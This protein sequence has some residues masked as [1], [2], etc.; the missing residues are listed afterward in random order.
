MTEDVVADVSQLVNYAC[1][2]LVLVVRHL[3]V[4]LPRRSVPSEGRSG[5][6]WRVA[7]A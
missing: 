1:A 3:D 6:C 7:L 4:S 5:R 2:V